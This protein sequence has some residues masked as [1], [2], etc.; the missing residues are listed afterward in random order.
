M[1]LCGNFLEKMFRPFL[2]D[3]EQ[4]GSLGSSRAKALRFQNARLS[5]LPDNGL[6]I[7]ASPLP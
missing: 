6:K 7:L 5:S 3:N 4:E 1:G 2:G